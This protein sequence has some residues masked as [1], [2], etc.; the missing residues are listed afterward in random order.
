[1]EKWEYTIAIFE[2]ST[3]IDKTDS[4][5]KPK[6]TTLISTADKEYASKTEM[7][8][9]LGKEGWELVSTSEL[10]P[11]YTPTFGLVQVSYIFKRPIPSTAEEIA[12]N[13]LFI[14]AR[15]KKVDEILKLNKK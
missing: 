3:S 6:T 12:E 7:L 2:I 8:N 5:E 10:I 15:S 13:M 4:K 1:M 14:D 9:D 11:P